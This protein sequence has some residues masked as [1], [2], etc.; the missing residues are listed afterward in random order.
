MYTND[1]QIT[2][3]FLKRIFSVVFTLI[4]DLDPAFI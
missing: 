4:S 3:Y 1:L 2:N